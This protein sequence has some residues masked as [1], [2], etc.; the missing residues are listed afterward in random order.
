VAQVRDNAPLQFS[1]LI[2]RVVALMVGII[3]QYFTTEIY[4]IDDAPRGDTRQTI[5][6]PSGEIMNRVR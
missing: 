1:N 5:N 6:I 3:V 2:V 4:I